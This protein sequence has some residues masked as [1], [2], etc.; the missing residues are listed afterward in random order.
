MH[1]KVKLHV[2]GAWDGVMVN[3]KEKQT[4][5]CEFESHRVP[6][7]FGYPSKKLSKLLYWL[8]PI[9]FRV[10]VPWKLE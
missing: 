4:F 2:L 10:L 3:K 6:N 7:S 8:N 1:S 5:T 9:Y